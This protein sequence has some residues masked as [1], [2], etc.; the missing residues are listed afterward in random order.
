[1]YAGT[2]PPEGVKAVL[3]TAA[4]HWRTFGCTSTGPV[5]ILHAKEQKAVLVL[6]AVEDQR[7]NGAG[8]V[9]H[10]K[11][12]DQL[13]MPLAESFQHWEYKL[14]QNSK[15]MYHQKQNNVSGMTHGVDFT[16]NG[17]TASLIELNNKSSGLYPIEKII[18]AK[19]STVWHDQC[20]LAQQ[21]TSVS[22][23]QFD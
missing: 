14:G 3:S 23:D 10:M 7:K 22:D 21:N 13:G 19:G 11:S 6:L 15:N 12:R 20:N 8:H 17:T 9:R 1:M 16:D 18:S 2:L 5:C 4:N